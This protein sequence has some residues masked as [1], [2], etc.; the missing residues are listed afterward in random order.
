M[1]VGGGGGGASSAT[2]FFFCLLYM[3]CIY[4]YIEPEMISSSCSRTEA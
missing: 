2:K 3:Y 4:M 1:C